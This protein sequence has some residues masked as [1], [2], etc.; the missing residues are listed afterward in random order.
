LKFEIRSTKSETNRSEI[1]ISNI[2]IRNKF[3][4]QNLQIRNEGEVA[5]SIKPVSSFW[6]SY[7]GFVS[8]FGLQIADFPVACFTHGDSQTTEMGWRE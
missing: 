2:E 1:R 4:C 8:D 5:N 6:I 3:K 7:F